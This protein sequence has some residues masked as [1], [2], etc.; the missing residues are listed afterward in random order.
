MRCWLI[1]WLWS[2]LSCSHLSQTWVSSVNAV[3]SNFFMFISGLITDCRKLLEQI[4][5]LKISNCFRAANQCADSLAR[6]GA[7]KQ[8]DF[9]VFNNPPLDIRFKL[10]WLVN[11]SILYYPK[12][13]EL[14]YP[15]INNEGRHGDRNFRSFL[16][17]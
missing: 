12:K 8:K 3:L 14:F 6:K 9:V 7:L 10:F 16:T 5:S 2:F 4:P 17:R 1:K 13:K 11:I 15:W